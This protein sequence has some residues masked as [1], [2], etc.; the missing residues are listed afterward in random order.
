MKRSI[1]IPLMAVVLAAP[2]STFAGEV[3]TEETEANGFAISLTTK[4]DE[5]L[6]HFDIKPYIQ[7][8]A[9]IL[10]SAILSSETEDQERENPVIEPEHI[11]RFSRYNETGSLLTEEELAS[12]S[13]E[14]KICVAYTEGMLTQNN[15]VMV[16]RMVANVM[17]KAIEEGVVRPT[18]EITKQ[19]IAESARALT[20]GVV[21]S[22]L[23][24]L[25]GNAGGPTP[26]AGQ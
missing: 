10:F 20:D 8:N 18:V 21:K 14:T 19:T 15:V 3:V 24:F 25:T 23:D 6:D 5:C 1:L 26:E 22:F 13:A 2:L 17:P 11:D 12:A 16:V 9:A 7:L 4:I